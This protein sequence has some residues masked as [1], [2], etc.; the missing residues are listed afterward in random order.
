MLLLPF[1]S[2]ILLQLLTPAGKAVSGLYSCVCAS[3]LA[4]LEGE[5]TNGVWWNLFLWRESQLFPAPRADALRLASESPSYI[6][7]RYFQT[8]AFTLD[9]GMSET[10]CEP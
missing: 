8:A 6:V 2:R 1:L 4:G 9:P 7:Y 10:R 3:M 5:C